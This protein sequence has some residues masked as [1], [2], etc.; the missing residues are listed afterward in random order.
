MIYLVD[1]DFVV[2]Y[3]KGRLK[4]V[5]LLTGLLDKGLAISIITFGEIYEGIYFGKDPKLAQRGFQQFLRGVSVLPLNRRIMKT[6]A[7]IRGELRQKREL[8]GDPDIM[9]AATAITNNLSLISRNRKD[10]QRVKGL[11]LFS[12]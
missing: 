8:I 7:L 1:I 6:F 12:E 10:F 2:D 4:S 3:L 11:R 5:E 9:I